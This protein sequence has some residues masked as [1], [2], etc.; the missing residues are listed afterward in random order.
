MI[1]ITRRK[2]IGLDMILRF[3]LGCSPYCLPGS[4][5]SKIYAIQYINL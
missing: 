1:K 3:S 5:F 4:I 2:T